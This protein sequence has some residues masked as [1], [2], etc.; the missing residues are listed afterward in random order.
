[1]YPYFF[2]IYLIKYTKKATLLIELLFFADGTIKTRLYI[3]GGLTK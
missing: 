2:N 1:M 3:K